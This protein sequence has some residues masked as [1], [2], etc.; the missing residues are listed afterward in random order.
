MKKTLVVFI[1]LGAAMAGAAFAAPDWSKAPTK[2]VPVFFPG[3]AGYEW[4][5]TK[6]DHSAANQLIEKGRTCAYCHDE[7]AIEI[8]GKMVAGKPVGNAKAPLET[9]PPKGKVGAFPVSIQGSH[10]G[11]KMTLRFEFDA[12]KPSGDKKMDPKNDLKLTV[13]FDDSKVDGARQNGCWST[14]HQDLRTMPDSNDAAKT[15]PKAKALGW[16]DGVT[17]YLKESRT[18]IEM[19]GKPRGGWDKLKSDAE[20]DALLKEGKF[21]DL[22]QWRSGKGEKPV[23]G[24][25]LD[26]RHMEGGKSLIKA[27]G[28]KEGDKWVITFERNLSADGKGDHAITDGK[29]Y[30]FGFAIH[31][32][33]AAARFH[34]VSLGYT[35]GLDN[36]K[37]DVNIVKQ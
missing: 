9:T 10:D 3:P 24:Y 6:S 15:N 17:K 26:A 23:D 16:S 33:G 7:D 13:M 37:A 4:V 5:M 12:P 11:K 22:M 14:C 31:T 35:F 8:G 2:K 28:K 20:I 19:K 18:A 25:V 32:D 36:P 1:V 27:E 29:L 30:N 34:Y 21:M